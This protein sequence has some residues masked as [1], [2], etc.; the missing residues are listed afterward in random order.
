MSQ[1]DLGRILGSQDGSEISRYEKGL[2]LPPEKHLAILEKIFNVSRFDLFPGLA[3][4]DNTLRERVAALLNQVQ[5]KNVV[6]INK[7]VLAF[8]AVLVRLDLSGE[9]FRENE[10]AD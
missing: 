6:G 10:A 9:G 1:L 4:S 2:R 3:D 7:K 5:R 8:K